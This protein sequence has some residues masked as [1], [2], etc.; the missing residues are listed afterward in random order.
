[1]NKKYIRYEKLLSDIKKEIDIFLNK[2]KEHNK[3][4]TIEDAMVAWFDEEFDGWMIINYPSGDSGSEKESQT[5]KKEKFISQGADEF[6][7]DNK[8]PAKRS[9]FRIHI[10]V[11]V[12]IIDT[13]MEPS[14]DEAEAMNLMGSLI[15]ISR[16]G[17]YFK[18]PM[19][20]ELSSIIKVM[21]ELSVVDSELR[22][23]KRSPW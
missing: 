22:I 21:I 17:F 12:K 11:P 15:N 16:G 6:G 7:K 14:S 18:S 1:M 8:A 20:I 2:K 3:D 10:E 13:L 9:H 23:L 4:L 19:T 5:A